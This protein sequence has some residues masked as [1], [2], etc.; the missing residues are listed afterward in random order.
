MCNSAQFLIAAHKKCVSQFAASLA[1]KLSTAL[2]FPLPP[3][4]T[5]AHPLPLPLPLAVHVHVAVDVHVRIHVRPLP[6]RPPTVRISK[7]LILILIYSYLCKRSNN[8]AST[9]FGAAAPAL[10]FL[11]AVHMQRCV[12]GH[13]CAY[14]CMCVCVS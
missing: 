1:V 7:M 2:S 9:L 10:C 13:T 3:S 5:L 14:M 6:A 12:R 4:A 11:I 8:F